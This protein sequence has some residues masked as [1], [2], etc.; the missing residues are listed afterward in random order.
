MPNEKKDSGPRPLP[1]A[2]ILF[3]YV[4]LA[5]TTTVLMA[6]GFWLLMLEDPDRGLGFGLLTLGTVV[7]LAGGWKIRWF[8]K[9][10]LMG[11]PPG[12]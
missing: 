11:P 7:L 10:G 6:A 3:V 9:K 4:V 2:A 12:P 8:Q 5:L 1:K